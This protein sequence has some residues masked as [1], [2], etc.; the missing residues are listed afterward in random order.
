MRF[1]RF[2][3]ELPQLPLVVGLSLCIALIPAWAAMTITWV[4]K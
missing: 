2:N 1:P 3:I 4:S